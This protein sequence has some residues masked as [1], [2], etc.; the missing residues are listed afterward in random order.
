MQVM[1]EVFIRT[2]PQQLPVILEYL[3][4]QAGIAIRT[5]K[6]AGA[7]FTTVR[8]TLRNPDPSRRKG[9]LD[10]VKSHSVDVDVTESIKYDNAE[11]NAASACV[12]QV[13]KRPSGRVKE[14]AWTS[15]FDFATGCPRCGT[16]A[17][18]VADLCI[19]HFR[20]AKGQAICE[21]LNGHIIVNQGL[22][23]ALREVCGR[24]VVRPICTAKGQVAR[25]F[26]LVPNRT[27]DRMSAQQVGIS[28][29]DQCDVCRRDGYYG[30][31]TTDWRP[32]FADSAV[33]VKDIAHTFECFGKSRKVA[34][35]KTS[36]GLALP[37]LVVGKDI[38]TFLI[39]L[40]NTG[41][42]LVP[43]TS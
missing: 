22:R 7:D 19:E 28:I 8:A 2:S 41:L 21:T 18:Q 30:S 11:I 26:Q 43:V 14:N 15:C 33:G 40:A 3:R 38:A 17:E 9:L 39:G 1:V 6:P 5:A 23:E 4:Q 27:L 42:S 25:W 35:E 13:V 32:R 36:V 37:R 24:D 12:I 29:E 16:G 31:R 10:F 34:G 20:P